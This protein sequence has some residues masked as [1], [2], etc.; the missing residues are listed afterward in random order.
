MLS[1]NLNKE[2]MNHWE[3]CAS[4]AYEYISKVQCD[5]KYSQQM[6]V[7]WHWTNANKEIKSQVDVLKQNL[8][9]DPERCC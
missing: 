7:M 3:A 5:R 4:N 9:A 1:L 2:T 8:A 6:S